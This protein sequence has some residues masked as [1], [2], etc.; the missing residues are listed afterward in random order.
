MSKCFRLL[1]FACRAVLDLSAQAMLKYDPETRQVQLAVDRPYQAGEPVLAWCGP[2][3]RGSGSFSPCMRS[4]A[5]GTSL[6]PCAGTTQQDM[7]ARHCTVVLGA[8]HSGAWDGSESCARSNVHTPTG[9]AARAQGLWVIT[10][11][12]PY[13]I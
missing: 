5:V 11:A 10:L 12:L 13:P 7:S 4:R 3:V 2:Q 1:S 8:E 6:R 9:G